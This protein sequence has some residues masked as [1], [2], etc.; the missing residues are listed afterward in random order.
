MIVPAWIAQVGGRSGEKPSQKIGPDL[1]RTSAAERCDG[2]D[3]AFGDDRR[4]VAEDQALHELVVGGGTIDRLVP[5]WR[6]R[7][8]SG[9]LG[10]ADGREQRDL[11]VFV[12]VD[13]DAQVDLGGAVS[14]LNA[15]VSPRIGSRGAISTAANSDGKVI[16][17]LILSPEMLRRGTR[18][19]AQT[20]ARNKLSMLETRFADGSEGVVLARILA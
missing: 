19:T 16:G 3:S 1:E 18:I 7:F 2:R 8:Q 15:S 12:Q 4:G 5:A 17:T 14:A 20:P 9:T 6:Q 11:A 10:G 13:A